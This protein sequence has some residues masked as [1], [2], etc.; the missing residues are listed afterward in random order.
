MFDKMKKVLGI[1]FLVLLLTS[2][3]I[4]VV[5]AQADQSQG[6]Q[7]A[8]PS[9]SNQQ[10]MQSGGGGRVVPGFWYCNNF[11]SRTQYYTNCQQR[12][13][14]ERGHWDRCQGKSVWKCDFGHW[15]WVCTGPRNA[16]YCNWNWCP[17][18]R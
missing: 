7:G 9:G 17:P 11:P 1:S 16:W 4:A 13:V 2:M 14:C 12:W 5:G 10:M 15:A 8:A 18:H 3:T 6:N